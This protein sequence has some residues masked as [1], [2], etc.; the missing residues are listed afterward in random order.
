[1]QRQPRSSGGRTPRSRKPDIPDDGLD[2]LITG[3]LT[4]SRALV[5]VSVRSLADIEDAVTPNQFRTLVVLSAHGSTRLV[6]LAR[7]LGVQASTALRSVD[8][9]VAGGLVDRREN[10]N[11]RREVQIDLTAAG[12]RLVRRV[13]DRRRAAIED[14]VRSMP[15]ARRQELLE[16]LDAFAAF[17]A[18]ADEPLADVDHASVL[19]W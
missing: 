17:A 11:D 2:D 14:I 9:L 1:M 15:K 5:G 16:A 12:R 8:R 3:I 7:R 10:E 19:G 6:E 4:A 13:T 18:A